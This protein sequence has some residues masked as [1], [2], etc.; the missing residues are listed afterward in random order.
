MAG[1]FGEKKFASS[2]STTSYFTCTE[3]PMNSNKRS[4]RQPKTRLPNRWKDSSASSCW[5]RT[6]PNWYGLNFYRLVVHQEEAEIAGG[7]P[8]SVVYFCVSFWLHGFADLLSLFFPFSLPFFIVLILLTISYNGSQKSDQNPKKSR[9]MKM[10]SFI[11]SHVSRSI[12][13]G[14]KTKTET[15]Y[16]QFWRAK[17]Q[18]IRLHKTNL[19]YFTRRVYS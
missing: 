12:V 7:N 2:T 14:R 13:K 6:D 4:W 10:S 5:C 9:N 1:K 11:H 18:K 3:S 19:Y 17:G 15:S 8:S 16:A